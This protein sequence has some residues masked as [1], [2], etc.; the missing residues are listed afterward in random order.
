MTRKFIP[1]DE[2]FR[3]WEKGPKF[4]VAYDALEDECALATAMSTTQAV[5]ARLE[6]GRIMPST[7]TIEPFAKTTGMKPRISFEPVP[8]DQPQRPSNAIQ[9]SPESRRHAG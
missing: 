8:R 2:A 9:R 5:V 7:R 4:Q 1:V 6:S 3:E